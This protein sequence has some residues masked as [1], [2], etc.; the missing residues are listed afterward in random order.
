[1]FQRWPFASVFLLSALCNLG[2]SAFSFA[3]NKL[4]IVDAL[5]PA[6]QAA[7]WGW[8]APAYNLAAYPLGLGMMAV[9]IAPLSRCLRDLRAGRPVRP[10]RLEQCRRRLVNLPV[11][12]VCINFLGWAPGAV[13]FPLGVCLLAGWDGAAFL[14]WHFIVSFLVTALLTTVQTFFLL[15]TFLLKVVYPEFFRDA[16]PAD[17]PGAW[18]L[19]LAG[20]LLLYWVATAV[21][22]VVSLLAIALNAVGE[23]HANLDLLGRLALAVAVGGVLSSALIALLVGRGLLGWVDAHGRATTRVAQE[24]YDHRIAE[25]RPD[26]LGRLTDRFNDMAEALGR[27]RALR[28]TVGQL[29]RPDVLE[30]VV[31]HHPQLGGEV[32][33]VTVLFADIR[34]FTLRSAGEAPDRVVGLLNRFF[35]LAVA[36]VEEEGGLVNKFLGD[37]FM[38]LFGVPRIDADHADRAVGAALRLLE[39]LDRLNLDLAAAGDEPLAV[40]VGIHTGPALVGCIGASLPSKDGRPRLLKEYTAVGETVNLGQRVEQLTK[41]LGG[42]V[43][44]TERTRDRLKLPVPL[45]CLGL[46]KPAGSE[47]IVVYR[48][49]ATLMEGR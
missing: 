44:I 32:R 28:Q 39:R 35:S 33:E 42:P 29:V 1:M 15:E 26:E 40:G 46:Q 4:L 5:S 2:G 43:L 6:Q 20:R 38:A 10:E 25:K 48:L 24:D 8:V 18:R 21:V 34:G 37:G 17:V 27:A 3:Y 7:F 49:D 47:G 14:W 19:P 41:K 9:L 30:E 13:F 23:R 12:Q 31:E 36:A 22:P 16:R 45:S 11:C